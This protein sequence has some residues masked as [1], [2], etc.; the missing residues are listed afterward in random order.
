VKN[1]ISFRNKVASKFTPKINNMLKTKN[2]KNIKKPASI[3]SLPP[4]ISAKLP[5]EVNN[6]NRFSKRKLLC[7]MEKNK[8]VS[9]ILRPHQLEMLRK[10]H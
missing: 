10:R 8:V 3:L 5:K 7:P 1:N 6:L 2:G 9:L 4:P